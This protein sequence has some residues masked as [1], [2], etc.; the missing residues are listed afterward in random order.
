MTDYRNVDKDFLIQKLTE[1]NERLKKELIQKEKVI[2][3]MDAKVIEMLVPRNPVEPEHIFSFNLDM[4][5]ALGFPG[6]RG[7]KGFYIPKLYEEVN[8][9]IVGK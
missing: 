3:W 9:L 1:E 7:Y 2:F 5:K 8:I 6:F 4:F